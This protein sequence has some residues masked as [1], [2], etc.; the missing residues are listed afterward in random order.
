MVRVMFDRVK[1]YGF[2]V[3]V[4]FDRVKVYGFMVRVGLKF[5]RLPDE[6]IAAPF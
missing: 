3:R 2:M 6:A 1:V 5:H 4:R